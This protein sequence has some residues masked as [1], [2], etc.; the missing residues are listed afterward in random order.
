MP[1]VKY[2]DFRRGLW[3]NGERDSIPEDALRRAHGISRIRDGLLRSARGYEEVNDTGSLGYQAF[4]GRLYQGADAGLY[5]DGILI[6]LIIMDGTRL[7]YLRMPA[8][9]ELTDYLFIAGGGNALKVLP[10]GAN[11]PQN[12]GIEPPTDP[13]PALL[14]SDYKNIDS[15]AV[16][17][18][19][20]AGQGGPALADEA[21]I[22][23][24]VSS[25][26]VTTG[27]V[28]I[29]EFSKGVV[30]DLNEFDN[31][32]DY[33]T[34]PSAD[35]DYIELFFR[36]E[37]PDNLIRLELSFS[38]GDATF[39]DKAFT[40]SIPV[41]ASVLQPEP[42]QQG[43]AQA[44][45]TPEDFTAG[46]VR[47]WSY[48]NQ[49]TEDEE[50]DVVNAEGPFSEGADF[51]DLYDSLGRTSIPRIANV[52]HKLRLPKASF[53]RLGFESGSLD[54]SDVEAVRISIVT[55][56]TSVVCYFDEIGLAGGAGLIG[57]Y[58][59]HITYYNENTGNR[60]NPNP[61]PIMAVKEVDRQG[62]SL[63]NLPTSL[64][65]QVTHVEIWRTLGNGVLFFKVG[66]VVNGTAS[67]QD[68][69]VD[70]RG[71]F[72]GDHIDE[73]DLPD[74][75]ESLE[76]PLDNTPPADTYEWVSGPHLAR[77]WWCA[78]TEP[79]ARGRLYYSPVGRPESVQGF[80]EVSQTN[81][82]T[83][84]AVA[85]NGIMY[86]WT[87]RTIYRVEG[88]TEPFAAFEVFG[89]EG[90][91]RP[92]TVVPTPFGVLY[93]SDDGVRIFNGLTS[94]LVAFDPIAPI[95]SGSIVENVF[96]F[97]GITAA[98]RHEEYWITNGLQV[99]VLDIRNQTWRVVNQPI[100]TLYCDCDGAQMLGATSTGAAAGE[101]RDL[102]GATPDE[103][104]EYAIQTRSQRVAVDSQGFV[105]RMF[106]EINTN[107]QDIVPS[108]IHD[109]GQLVCP[110]INNATRETIEL[111][112]GVS[113]RLAAVRLTGTVLAEVQLAGIELDV[114]VPGSRGE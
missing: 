33:S 84:C 85:W 64:D 114:Y 93:Q 82:P 99:L 87:T 112:V 92:Y 16:A 105:Q 1:R 44:K 83:Q 61:N 21:T 11:I 39:N 81:E 30:V 75:M 40:R 104:I 24:G 72:S 46:G 36:C 74:V 42:E 86:V 96:N 77:A 6:P 55:D 49:F 73:A 8:Q 27:A 68:R 43:V 52:W 57:K 102:E 70:F 56:G 47:Q 113:T 79:E 62:L 66:Q 54:W 63:T 107:G 29:S 103:A 95:L 2:R 110:T 26:K 48:G 45:P 3:L 31:D 50:R 80:I 22:H 89:A 17:G 60:S 13:T 58:Q 25:M 5:Q 100:S 88:D 65:P 9:P 19:W 71:L 34:D 59:H 14:T 106:I 90:T 97:V 28:V 15:F 67:F 111:P 23:L 98:Y 20:T 18:S 109:G 4:E 78:D 35:Q 53:N 12:W 101:T 69:V 94:E 108:L 7:N 37:N 41:E 76:L 10:G 32:A 51:R 38:V 91:N